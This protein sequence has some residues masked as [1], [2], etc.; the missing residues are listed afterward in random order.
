MMDLPKPLEKAFWYQVK[1]L[2]EEKQMPFITTP[3]RYGR[4]EGLREGISQ[5]VEVRNAIEH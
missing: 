4:E 5:G 3:E 1:Q 2:R